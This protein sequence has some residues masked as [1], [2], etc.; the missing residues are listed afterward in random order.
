LTAFSSVNG[1]VIATFL[2]FYVSHSSE[3]GVRKRGFLKAAKML[4]YVF[5]YKIQFPQ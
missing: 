1:R 3:R 5:L 4:L 2:N